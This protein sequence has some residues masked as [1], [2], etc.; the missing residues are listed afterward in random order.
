MS[1]IGLISTCSM[2]WAAAEAAMSSTVVKNFFKITRMFCASLRGSN[3]AE[4][5]VSFRMRFH[6]RLDFSY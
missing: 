3:V 4:L 6:G 2:F 5:A 1:L